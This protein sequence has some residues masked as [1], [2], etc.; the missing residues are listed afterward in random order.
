MAVTQ[1][2]TLGFGEYVIVGLLSTLATLG[3]SPI[4]GSA[5][6]F[7]VMICDAVHVPVSSMYAVIVAIDWF[8]DRFRIAFSASGDAFAAKIIASV[9][10]WKDG[11]EIPYPVDV[12]EVDDDNASTMSTVVSE[13]QNYYWYSQETHGVTRARSLWD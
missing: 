2:I 8:I 6:V 1:G 4:P 9:T 7:V 11:D 12:K 5:L 3:A 13:E 10:G